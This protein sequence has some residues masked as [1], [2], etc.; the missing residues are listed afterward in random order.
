MTHPHAGLVTA[1]GD[2][3]T[4]YIWGSVSLS[5]NVHFIVR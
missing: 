2:K 3:Y 1:L 4:V 5:I